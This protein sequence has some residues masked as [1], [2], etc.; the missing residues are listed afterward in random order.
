MSHAG[1]RKNSLSP[2]GSTWA[3]I[4]RREAQDDNNI[5]IKK[6]LS[7]AHMFVHCRGTYLGD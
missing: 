4:L 5:I 1:K 6:A 2:G 3:Q 7:G